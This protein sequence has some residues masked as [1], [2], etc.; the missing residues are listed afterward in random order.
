ML[1]CQFVH[2]KISTLTFGTNHIEENQDNAIRELHIIAES[3]FWEAFQEWKKR[4][5]WYIACG[6]DYFEGDCA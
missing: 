1:L 2:R 4:W 5:E 3:A 6:G